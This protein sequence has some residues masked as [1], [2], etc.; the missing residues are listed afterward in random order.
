[1]KW[2]SPKRLKELGII[3][4]NKRN[5]GYIMPNN[6][7]KLYPLVDDKVETKKLAIKAGLA[8]PKLYGVITTVQEIKSRL[9]QIMAQHDEFV[10]KP[11]KGAG[12][13][14]IL[15]I[16]GKTPNGFI[17]ANGSEISQKDVFTH[18]SNIL[19]GLYSLGGQLDNA[20]VEY[21][22][23][24]SDIFTNIS[25]QGIP[26]VRL[27][28][29]KGFPIMGM[30]RLA[31]KD[32]DGKANLH[33]GAIGAGINIASGKTMGG[34]CKNKRV[35]IH[36]DTE[37][38]IEGV[39]IPEWDKML[40]IAASSYE[41][42]GLGYLGSD[43][44]LDQDLGPLV[45]ELNARPGLAIQIANAQGLEKRLIQIDQLDKRDYTVSERIDIAKML[46]NQ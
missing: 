3:G 27:I 43:I 28:V 24:F 45:L 41:M 7:R 39:L 29:Y 20:M 32:S 42:T 23:H 38:T 12:G 2:I 40:Q 36:P 6:P 26:D 4:M 14:G 35:V 34:V 30:L 8:V 37:H 5:R 9:P 44:V 16:V 17:K 22:V 25:Y 21:R 15:V 13:N 33:Q 1:M 18:V 19:S 46:F 10:I 31:T 11:S